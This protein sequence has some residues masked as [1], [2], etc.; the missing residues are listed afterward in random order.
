MEGLRAWPWLCARLCPSLGV[1]RRVQEGEDLNLLL[2]AAF[3]GSPEWLS[4]NSSAFRA[5][6]DGCLLLCAVQNLVKMCFVVVAIGVMP[7]PLKLAHHR[8]S[9][10][11]KCFDVDFQ[12]DYLPQL[13]VQPLCC[14]ADFCSQPGSAHLSFQTGPALF[15]SAAPFT[16]EHVPYSAG[17]SFLLVTYLSG[18]FRWA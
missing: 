8:V 5:G 9:V 4:L 13:Q 12:L 14:L 16:L 3:D 10:F 17:F 7:R 1:C 18:S 11:S 6:A 2:T 15:S